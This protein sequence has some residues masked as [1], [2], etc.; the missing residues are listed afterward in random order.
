VRDI[1]I[2]K[3]KKK[4]DIFIYF[5]LNRDRDCLTKYCL[6]IFL[7]REHEEL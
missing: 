4:R 6:D 7:E 2:I 3:K 5:L 1:F